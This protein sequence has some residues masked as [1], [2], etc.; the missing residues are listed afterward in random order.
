MIFLVLYLIIYW[1]ESENLPNYIFN[2]LITVS[3]TLKIYYDNGYP[4][5]DN[6]K[7]YYNNHRIIRSLLLIIIVKYHYQ[8]NNNGYF[9]LVL[10]TIP[11]T[12]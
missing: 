5:D 12:R 1:I 11:I 7:N 2:D 10:Y 8:V 3:V 9:L 6:D 4:T